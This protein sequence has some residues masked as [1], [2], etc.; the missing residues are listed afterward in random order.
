[1]IINLY[2][3]NNWARIIWE[4]DNTGRP[5]R[6]IASDMNISAIDALNVWVFD[7]FNANERR[8]KIYPPYKVKDKKNET[9][10]EFYRSLDQLKEV[11]LHT[12]AL[13]VRVP[14]YEADDVITQLAL[15]YAGGNVHVKIWSTD[16]DY[17]RLRGHP[18]ITTSRE[19]YKDLPFE[20]IQLYKATVGDSSD[21]IKGIPG[22]GPKGWD[23]CHKVNLRRL[24]EVGDASPNDCGLSKRVV[25]WLEDPI[26]LATLRAMY[27]VVDF[28]PV[29]NNLI[30]NLL[31]A[32]TFNRDNQEEVF[33]A[34]NQ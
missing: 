2:D 33:K 31:V 17:Q 19:G 18:N 7:G 32:G 13:Q 26:H 8:R 22:F 30:D 9:P 23:V 3:A 27:Q 24:I 1:M 34:F 11:L 4:T 12:S 5:L 15:R 20:D 28:M 25:T 21:K 6:T 29:P 10:D 16:G 14:E